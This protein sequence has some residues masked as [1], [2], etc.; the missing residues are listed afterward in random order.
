ML[1]AN[2]SVLDANIRRPFDMAAR[3]G[4]EEFVMLLPDTDLEGA[5]MVAEAIHR[6][7]RSLRIAHE[8]S[9]YQVVTASIG[10]AA[11][12]PSREGDR[13][14]LLEAADKALYEAKAAGRNC[15]R[16]HGAPAIACQEQA[17]PNA[18]P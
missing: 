3:Y 18:A 5:R 11:T 15:I 7:L 17:L 1:C 6:A 14:S 2:A 13:A 9:P 16:E 8:G 4:G 10:A 12:Q